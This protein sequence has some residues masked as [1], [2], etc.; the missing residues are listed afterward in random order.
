ML[1]AVVLALAGCA[2]AGTT[3]AQGN[4]APLPKDL[5]IFPP[6]PDIPKEVA[7]FSGLWIG[8]WNLVGPRTG[9]RLTLNAALA[10]TKI[11]RTPEGTYKAAVISSWG[12]S[13]PEWGLPTA[14]WVPLEGTI[15]DGVLRVPSYGASPNIATYRLD[16]PTAL[17]ATYTSRGGTWTDH[18]RLRRSGQ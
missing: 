6:G 13:P 7:A 17:M 4:L 1:V 12:P 2:A 9:A 8:A 5:A 10:V 3:T 11:E 14:S 18:G 15:E 16:G